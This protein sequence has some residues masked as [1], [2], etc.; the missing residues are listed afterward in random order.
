[1][2]VRFRQDIAISALG[3]RFQAGEIIEVDESVIEGLVS[4]G[5]VELVDA[6]GDGVAEDPNDYDTW[7]VADLK[8]EVE[9]RGLTLPDSPGTGAGGNWIKSDYAALLRG[10]DAQSGSG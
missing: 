1:M 2:K 4:G 7:T 10:D 6:D 3:G 8:A 9:R 5:Y